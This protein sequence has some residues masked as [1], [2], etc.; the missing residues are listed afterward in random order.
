MKVGIITGQI[1]DKELANGCTV[2]WNKLVNFFRRVFINNA[3]LSWILFVTLVPLIVI[4]YLVTSASK[5]ALTNEI[6]NNLTIIS[7]KKASEIE[8]FILESK[9]SA[10]LLASNPSIVEATKKLTSAETTGSQQF[11]HEAQTLNTFLSRYLQESNYTNIIILSS[12]GKVVYSARQPAILNHDYSA[13][14]LKDSELGKGF[15]NAK[16]LL[17]TSLTD[18]EKS[19]W[20]HEPQLYITSPIM[21]KNNVIGVLALQMSNVPIIKVVSDLEG[22]G[23][24]GETLAGTIQ[25]G[26]IKPTIP[27]RH[28]AMEKFNNQNHQ[29]A[30]MVSAFKG[31]TQGEKG[32]ATMTDHRGKKVLAAWQYLP[33]MDWGLLIK[34]DQ[35]EVL[36]PVHQLIHRIYFL[37][38]ITSLLAFSLSYF[39]ARRFQTAENKEKQLMSEL[40]KTRNEALDANR[41]KSSFLANMSHE[42][43][44]PLNA[45]IGYSEILSEDAADLQMDGFVADLDKI[46]SAGKHLLNLINDILDISKIE[47]GKMDN[48]VEEVQLAPLTEEL[49]MMV[50]P[51][52]EKKNNKLIVEYPQDIGSINTDRTKLRQCLLN[53]ISNANKFTDDGLITLS[54]SRSVEDSEPWFIF[55]V[56]DTG[57]GMSP[58]Q[59]NRI[60]EAFTQADVSTT[61]RYGGTG[62]GLYLTQKFINL[63]DGKIDVESRLNKGTTFTISLPSLEA[64]EQET[65]I[66]PNTTV[67]SL[68]PTILIIDDDKNFHKALEEAL[69]HKFRIVHSYDGEEGLKLAKEILPDAI[70]LDVIMPKLDGWVVLGA[71]RSNPKLYMIPVIMVSIATDK[72]LGYTLGVADYLVKPVKPIML[73][74][75]IYKHIGKKNPYILVVDDNAGTRHLIIRMLK[76][77]GMEVEEASNGKEAIEKIQQRMPTIILLDLMMPIMDGFQVVEHLRHSKEWKHIPIIIIT[78]KDLTKEDQ[79]RLKGS[80]E[81]ILKKSAYKPKELIN[82]IHKQIETSVNLNQQYEKGI[83]PHPPQSVIE[84]VVKENNK[85]EDRLKKILL[86]ENNQEI[87]SPL[88]EELSSCG[89]QVYGATDVNSGLLLATKEHCGL[90]I[91]NMGLPK[92]DDWILLSQSIELG[93]MPIILVTT[94]LNN[95]ATIGRVTGLIAKKSEE[96]HVVSKI[97]AYLKNEPESKILLLTTNETLEKQLEQAGQKNS[98]QVNLVSDT[99]S[100]IKQAV[101]NPPSMILLDSAAESSPLESL[102]KLQQAPALSDIPTLLLIE[103][104]PTIETLQHLFE[105]A[106]K[107]LENKKLNIETLLNY[108]ST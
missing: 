5:T 57:I 48:Y 84:K 65:T 62:L 97:N 37:V 64:S 12:A 55:K 24:T 96:E 45:I 71:I 22:L 56:T 99:S 75:T 32:N 91:L 88:T 1:Q 74:Q 35:D 43:R 28:T 100:L 39:V 94:I 82:F 77:V 108:I 34:L 6:T 63:L 8:N 9:R 13:L 14:P 69:S 59:L 80:V 106:P 103:G 95:L 81:F 104:S 67:Q 41:A 58:D 86:I 54:I 93:T 50:M 70:V 72:D 31:A 85:D 27:L 102:I 92:S 51:L 18:F 3:F 40:E 16:T 89:Y 83:I 105:I 15:D 68:L 46:N 42:L 38:G 33:S 73:M 29:Q 19:T 66:S 20:Y 107:I 61:R 90:T 30:K 25:N 98:W 47:A 79:L 21:E 52:V 87:V 49:H 36:E 10:S 101:K 53:L 2:V 78:A 17:E 7:D 60:F 4:T 44:T 76:R 11:G 26:K 23:K